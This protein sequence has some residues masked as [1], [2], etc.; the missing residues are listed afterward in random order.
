MSSIARISWNYPATKPAIIAAMPISH[1]NSSKASSS[2]CESLFSLTAAR[3]PDLKL[4]HQERWCC[5]PL[6]GAT[7]TYKLCWIKHYKTLDEIE[8][9]PRFDHQRIEEF[10]QFVSSI[11]LPLTPRNKITGKFAFSYPLPIRLRTDDDLEKATKVLMHALY[12]KTE[13]DALKAI[14]T[15]GREAGERRTKGG[16]IPEELANPDVFPEGGRKTV[17]IN[18]YER[19]A[20]ARNACIQHFGAKCSACGLE[21]EQ[22]YGVLGK[23]FIHVHHMV[24]IAK[25]GKAYKVDPKKDLRPVC[26]NCHAM[27]HRTEPALTIERLQALLLRT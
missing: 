18:A 8:I 12:K 10:Q 16:F 7:G 24:E 4:E 26:P 25:I 22:M 13:T 14:K 6:L 11:G 5:F 19:S 27:L 21:F 20:R 9:Y 3:L 23:G 1:N 17:T 15:S 2:L